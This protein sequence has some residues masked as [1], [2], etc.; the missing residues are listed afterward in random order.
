[1]SGGEVRYYFGCSD[2]E[3]PAGV[4]ANLSPGQARLGALGGS[5]EAEA[6][7]ASVWVLGMQAERSVFAFVALL[8]DYIR[9]KQTHPHGIPGFDID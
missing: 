8:S 2:E 4:L 1:M 5:S 6:L 3:V 7:G 9:L